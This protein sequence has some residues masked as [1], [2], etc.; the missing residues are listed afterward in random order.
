MTSI[1]QD[2]AALAVAAEIRRA[3]QELP[4]GTAVEQLRNFC[5]RGWEMLHTP[6]F[7]RMYRAMVNEIAGS[8]EAGRFYAHE[9]CAPILSALTGIIGRGIASS[10]FRLQNPHFAARMILAALI[11][12]AFWCNHAEVVG[13]EL[14]CG[15]NRIVTDTL[16]IVLGG[17]V[18]E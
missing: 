4:P 5:G 17:M 9:V 7:D 1:S 12:Q 13:P 6:E 3:C 18:R 2:P 8:S 11:Q 16:S 14:G 15:C 10:E